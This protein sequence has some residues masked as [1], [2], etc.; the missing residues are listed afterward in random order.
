MI[1]TEYTELEMR[2]VGCNAKWDVPVARQVNVKTHPDARLGI[3]LGTMH[4]TRCPVCK[5]RR[6]VE[7]IFE[8]YD[9]D[10]SLLL[11]IRPDW[12]I[13]AGG[14]ED[15]YWERY[16][17]LVKK[18]AEVDVKVDVVF[19]M[20]EMVEKY[21]GGEDARAWA[22]EEWAAREA[23]KEEEERAAAERA[24]T[25]VSEEMRTADETEAVLAE[26]TDAAAPEPAEA[27]DE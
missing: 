6:D 20:S 7:F 26:R 14:G 18:Y 5:K 17:D 11:Q 10:Q 19:G 23:A 3:L 2:C 16:E 22:R 1:E 8:Y 13:I 12:E 4:R 15:W 27:T 24:A 21:L 25:A 9:P